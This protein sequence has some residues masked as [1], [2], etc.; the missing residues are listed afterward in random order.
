VVHCPI[1][2]WDSLAT[3]YS[4]ALGHSDFF[5]F[6]HQPIFRKNTVIN[7]LEYIVANESHK[8]IG[9]WT[10]YFLFFLST[11]S[12]KSQA[13]GGTWIFLFPTFNRVNTISTPKKNFNCISYVR[14][15]LANYHQ[16]TQN[17]EKH[18]YDLTGQV[19]SFEIYLWLSLWRVKLDLQTH[20][21][22]ISI[23]VVYGATPT[24]MPYKPGT[25]SSKCWWSIRVWHL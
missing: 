4:S 2:L 20:R 23:Q 8:A 15:T 13:E 21:Q 14:F 3:I 16:A 17:T 19:T 9:Q 6:L 11:T 22:S 1:A 18:N 25:K 10:T 5:L 24:K 7:A 12:H